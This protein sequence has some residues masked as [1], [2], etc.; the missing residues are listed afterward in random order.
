[1]AKANK[2]RGEAE[3]ELAGKRYRLIPSFENLAEIEART[4]EKFLTF[5]NRILSGEIGLRDAAMVLAACAEPGL[6]EEEA[7]DL[8]LKAGFYIASLKVFDFLSHALN[9]EVAE[10]KPQATDKTRKKR[11]R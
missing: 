4:G 9:T 2:W 10:G 8:V 7:G 6:S 11:K 3:I 5:L 1:M